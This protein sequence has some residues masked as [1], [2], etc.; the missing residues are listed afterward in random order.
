MKIWIALFLPF[1][2]IPVVSR[3]NPADTTIKGVMIRFGYSTTIFP[4]SWQ[5]SPISAKG[6]PISK[7][8]IQRCKTV[9]IKALSKY[10]PNALQKELDA[11]YFLKSMKFYDVG[12]GGTNSTDALYLTDDGTES[13]YTDLYLEQTFHHEYS[14][15]LYRNHPSFID[16]E[17]WKKAN[18]AGFDYNDPENGVGAIR[19]N[20]SSQDLDT[21]LCKKGFLTQYSLSGMENDINT[22]AQNIFSPSEGF[23][24]IVDQ[25]PRIRIKTRLLIDFYNKID[26]LFTY[27]YFRELNK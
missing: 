8:E 9:M 23:W 26:P 20:E 27:N 3:S 24:Q 2:S 18:I 13:G 11:V 10:P 12:Y 7:S 25:Y 17:A 1:I 4:E 21:L 14:S 5:P 19:N 6:E 22:F 16:E 15:I